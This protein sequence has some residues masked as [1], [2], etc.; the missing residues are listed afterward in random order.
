MSLSKNQRDLPQLCSL[1]IFSQMSLL[2]RISAH[3]VCLEWYHRVREVN[4]RTVKSLTI[5]FKNGPSAV[6]F[7]ELINDSK[8][9]LRS[10]RLLTN[11]DGSP[12]FAM[13]RLTKCNLFRLGDD[14]QLNLITLKQIAST[15]PSIPELIFATT[16]GKKFELLTEMLKNYHWQRQL[17]SLKVIFKGY[18]YYRDPTI[19]QPLFTAINSL[20]ALKY[21]TL[22]EVE[23]YDL[24]ILVQLNEISC[25]FRELFLNSLQQYAVKNTG[26]LSV[27]VSGFVQLG[28]YITVLSQ[29]SAQLR[30]SINCLIFSTLHRNIFLSCGL[31]FPNLTVLYL[32]W[33][34]YCR[35]SELFTTLSQLHRLQQLSLEIDLTHFDP[36][37]PFPPLRAQLSSVVALDLSLRLK[38][39][40]QVHLLSLHETMPN[41]QAIDFSGVCCENC[42]LKSN[43]HQEVLGILQRSTRIPPNRLSY[44]FDEKIYN[45]AENLLSE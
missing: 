22:K 30:G 16:L 6:N 25:E 15:F 13:H 43:C 4:H 34:S 44:N 23:L 2:D 38:A 17:I 5:I 9:I 39:H 35:F 18:P 19:L 27:K 42:E 26:E 3:Q 12:Q 8:N 1:A 20:P 11:S 41:L 21:L 28:D 10:A 7:T 24:P 32:R 29:L 40:S 45:F 37:H 36:K 14:D 33:P 31:F